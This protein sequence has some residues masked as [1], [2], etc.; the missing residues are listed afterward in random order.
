M[1]VILSDKNYLFNCI[2][3][4]TAIIGFVTKL[5]MEIKIREI[6]CQQFIQ[7]RLPPRIF[8]KSHLICYREKSRTERNNE[9]KFCFRINVCRSERQNPVLFCCTFTD[10]PFRASARKEFSEGLP[11]LY[12]S[13]TETYV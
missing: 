1:N 2:F 9:L 12:R 4:I 7:C 3:Y 11:T 6:H 8:P 13:V 5:S 10:F